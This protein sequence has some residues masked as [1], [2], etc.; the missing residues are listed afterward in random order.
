MSMKD[1]KIIVKTE[2]SNLWWG[3]YGF[4][5]KTGWE[6]L[7]LFTEDDKLICG[8]CLNAKAYLQTE[9]KNLK[10]NIEEKE[11][12]EAIGNYL[13]DD[14]CHYWYYYDD[15]HHEEVLEV[16]Y[17]APK[18]S[19]GVK[20]RFIDIMH[21]DRGIGLSTIKTGIKAFAKKHLGIDDCEVEIECGENFEESLKSFKENEKRLG[22]KFNV[23]EKFTDELIDDLSEYWQISREEVLKKLKTL[24]N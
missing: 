21:P 6:D 17:N 22:G 19:K 3:I 7:S 8:V 1:K 9:L 16:E 18:N 24:K 10:N 5:D 4:C 23:I 20:P 14:K 15:A 13:K 12:L 11:Y 2:S